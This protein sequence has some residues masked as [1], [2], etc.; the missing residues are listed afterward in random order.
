MCSVFPVQG[1]EKDALVTVNQVTIRRSEV[2]ERAYRQFGTTVIN[3]MADEILIRQAV[4][5]LKVKADDKEV[6][7]RLKRIQGQFPDEATFKTKLTQSGLGLA[8]LRGQIQDQVLR[9]SLLVKAKNITVTDD[10]AKEFFEANKARLGQPEAVRLRHIL[11]GTA[12]EAYDFMVAIRAGADFA[13]LASQVS[14]D[15]ATK[16]RGGELGLMARGMLQPDIE[17]VVFSLKT[18]E[19]GGPVKT[20]LGFHLLKAEETRAAKPALYADVKNDLKQALWTDKIA[21]AWPDYLRELREKARYEP[22]KET[23]VAP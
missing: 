19:V 3:Q 8:E 1:K 15:E 4:E 20:P 10:D 17:K 12:K 22:V 9:E 6:N 14:M 2:A 7:A 21:K 5:R 23:R 16:E 13:K 18:G 11:L